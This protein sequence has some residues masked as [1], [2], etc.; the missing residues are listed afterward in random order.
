MNILE[1][2]ACERCVFFLLVNQ[3]KKI[4]GN[5]TIILSCTAFSR[6]MER[7]RDIVRHLDRGRGLD[8]VS[9]VKFYVLLLNVKISGVRHWFRRCVSMRSLALIDLL[10]PSTSKLRVTAP[11][12]SRETR[13]TVPDPTATSL[14]LFWC[15]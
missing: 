15:C 4:R 8:I 6:E 13:I 14:V 5:D 2:R 3:T 1:D 12:R 11:S 10:V 9:R 7:L